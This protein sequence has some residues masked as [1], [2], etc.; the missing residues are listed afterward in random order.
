MCQIV[1]HSLKGMRIERDQLFLQLHDVVLVNWVEQGFHLLPELVK[2]I[3]STKVKMNLLQD[4]GLND[5][6]NIILLDINNKLQLI[7]CCIQNR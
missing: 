3:N 5:P 6:Y 2:I 4:I 1:L 7:V